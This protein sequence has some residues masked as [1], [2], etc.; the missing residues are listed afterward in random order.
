MPVGNCHHHR[1]QYGD[2]YLDS[3]IKTVKK[4]V[5]GGEVVNMHF[6]LPA[7]SG[8]L[9]AKPEAQARYLEARSQNSESRSKTRKENLA[10]LITD[11]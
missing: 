2:Y 9:S 4:R 10:L 5:A 11:Y 7:I 3:R 8:Q 6:Q 1:E